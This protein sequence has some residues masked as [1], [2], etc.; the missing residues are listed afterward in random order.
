MKQHGILSF[1]LVV[2]VGC[3]K[4]APVVV[5]DGWWSADF[6][7]ETCLRANE[8][9]RENA[10]LISK[11]GC[12]KITSCRE[13]MPVVEACVLDP[14]QDVRRFENDLATEFASNAEC[15]SV[16]FVHFSDPNESR[17]VASDAMQ[18]QHYSLSLDFSP[19]ARRQQWKMLSSPNRSA[20]TQGEGSPQEI[21]KKVCFIVKEQGATLAN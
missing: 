2:L 13:M 16:Q 1:L 7:K 20:F 12:D 9:H 5:L 6:A 3:S 11:V 10:A 17:K 8:W 14:V 4:P 15:R 18:K 21:A 19:G